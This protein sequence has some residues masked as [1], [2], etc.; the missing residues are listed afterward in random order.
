VS[1]FR[2]VERLEQIM[3][4]AGADVGGELREVNGQA[5]HVHLLVNFPPAIASLGWSIR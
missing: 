2:P 1:G 4:D 5:I 3:R